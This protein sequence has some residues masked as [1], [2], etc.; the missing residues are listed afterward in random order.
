[1]L[2][3]LHVVTD[4]DVLGRPDFPDIA[5]AL[6]AAHGDAIALHLRGRRTAGRR[7][8]ELASTLA[9]ESAATGGRVL[10]NDRADVAAASG[11]HGVHLG[12]ASIPPADARTLL[13]RALI[14]RSVH[15]A[16]GI[17]DVARWT[18]FL[19]L[20]TI[21]PTPSHPD[22]AGLGSDAL[23]AAAAQT[24]VPV[25]AIGGITPGHVPDLLTAGAYGVAVIRGVWNVADPV[26]AAGKYLARLGSG[27]AGTAG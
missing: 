15:T 7:L 22:A 21:Y 23:S 26:E 17:A 3:R 18:D 4:D 2:P 9:G 12:E 1:M 19:F 11:A 24:A 6:L 16:E 14:G 8:F 27:A 13:P 5:R 20:G 10:V 25:L